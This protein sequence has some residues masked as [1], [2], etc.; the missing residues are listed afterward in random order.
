MDVK[1]KSNFKFFGLFT[2]AIFVVILCLS[3]LHYRSIVTSPAAIWHGASMGA[4]SL[5]SGSTD[6]TQRLNKQ[7]IAV[8][9]KQIDEG[10]LPRVSI[11]S[12]NQVQTTEVDA[13]MQN[14]RAANRARET[15]LKDDKERL[16]HVKQQV[17]SSQ[18]ALSSLNQNYAD[19]AVYSEMESAHR[20]SIE[21]SIETDSDVPNEES[22]QELLSSKS[23]RITTD[24]VIPS[25]VLDNIQKT[26]GISPEEINELMNK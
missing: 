10:E 26:T 25:A 8:V 14:Q 6:S 18:S 4:R 3:T 11:V 17:L 20:A 21:E 16:E 13:Q 23:R 5:F 19:L 2:V 1:I 15:Q 12:G 24:S 7:T 9:N 22:I